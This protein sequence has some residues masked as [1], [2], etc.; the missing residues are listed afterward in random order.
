MNYLRIAK[1]SILFFMIL[2][3]LQ[4]TAMQKEK[5]AQEQLSY[6]NREVPRISE[7]EE[8]PNISNL[9]IIFV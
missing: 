7:L 8:N 4:I 6:I 3:V 1:F 9:I 5:S 2:G